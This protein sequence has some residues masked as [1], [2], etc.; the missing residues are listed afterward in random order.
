MHPL[1]EVR[2]FMKRDRRKRSIVRTVERFTRLREK[3]AVPTVG[4]LRL[5]FILST[6]RK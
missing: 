5:T 1:D 3:R 2:E 4:D 6:L